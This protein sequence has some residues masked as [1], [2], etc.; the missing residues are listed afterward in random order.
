MSTTAKRPSAQKPAK[1]SPAWRQA[2]VAHAEDSIKLEGGLDNPVR[3]C[4]PAYGL[5]IDGRFVDSIQAQRVSGP[6]ALFKL[7]GQLVA[8]NPATVAV[9]VVYP[10]F[11]GGFGEDLHVTAADIRAARRLLRSAAVLQ[12]HFGILL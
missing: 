1:V 7:A 3:C 10:E 2:N 4:R 6:E 8:H 9:E 11:G 5:K 12:R